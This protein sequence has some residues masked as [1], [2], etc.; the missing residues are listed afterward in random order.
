MPLATGRG[1]RTTWRSRDTRR[2]RVTTN[3]AAVATWRPGAWVRSRLTRCGRR[4]T[5]ACAARGADAAH[6]GQTPRAPAPR[7]PAADPADLDIDD[8][9][10]AARLRRLTGGP[11]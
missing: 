2:A 3:G 10:L 4:L 11:H 1:P 6:A 7:I 9:V 5:N 8:A